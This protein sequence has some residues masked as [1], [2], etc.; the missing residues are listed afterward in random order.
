MKTNAI[1]LKIVIPALQLASLIIIFIVHFRL[2]VWAEQT[3]ALENSDFALVAAIGL[4]LV[5]L[6]LLATVFYRWLKRR[7]ASTKLDVFVLSLVLLFFGTV[8]T[9]GIFTL[10]KFL[11]HGH[12]TSVI[13]S[14]EKIHKAQNDFR[15]IHNRYATLRELIDTDLLHPNLLKEEQIPGYRFSES[16]FSASTYCIH[17]DRTINGSGYRDFNMTE[18]GEIRFIETRA[19][20]TVRRGQGELLHNVTKQ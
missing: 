17:V 18:S 2:V 13:Q 16:D 4:T 7:W 14:L 9:W 8:W 12:H 5:P 15:T 20:G 6:A 3:Y 1:V 19:K 11:K 10:N